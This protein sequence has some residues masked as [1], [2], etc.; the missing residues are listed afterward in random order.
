MYLSDENKVWIAQGKEKICLIPRMANRHGLISGA[1]GTGKTVTLKVLSESFSDMGVPVFLADIK[2]DLSGICQ[3]GENN[4]HI[5]KRI[6]KLGLK[7]FTFNA[8]PTRF[9]DVYGKKGIP[10]RTTISD[11]GSELLSRLLN[12]NDTQSGILSMIFKIAD[13]RK[14]LLLDSKDL[15]TMIQYVGAH[16]ADFGSDYGNIAPQSI[17]AI[18][19]SLLQLEEQGGDVFFGEPALDISDW[20]QTDKNGRGIINILDCVELF[21]SPMLY[22]TFLLWMLSELYENLPE[23]GDLDKPKM[24]FFF[25]EAHL[26]FDDA[27]K[28]LLRK[29]EQVVRLIRSKGIGV[30]FV[31]QLPSDI[32]DDVLSQLGNKIQHALHAYTPKDQKA[33]K[34]AAQSFRSNSEFDCMKAISELGTGEALLSFLD[35]DGVPSIVQQG[36]ILPPMSSTVPIDD[37]TRTQMIK[38]DP[39]AEKYTQSIDRKSAFEDLNAQETQAK[40]E[41]AQLEAEKAQAKEKKAATPHSNHAGKSPLEKTLDS[42]MSTIGRELGK[43]IMRGLFGGR[44]R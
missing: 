11:M 26:L 37:T 44:K 12:L 5:Q 21:N 19:R 14:L 30:Y 18:Q 34:A 6:E 1:T 42:A 8:Y 29:I 3:K 35:A 24:I 31:S 38:N 22:S 10:V 28:S 13:D 15:R 9:F 36:I 40:N 4:S 27:P 43:N 25:D 7:D 20:M 39:L 41:T 16:R 23:S 33:L 32:P 2:G 17:G